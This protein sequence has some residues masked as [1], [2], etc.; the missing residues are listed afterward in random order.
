MAGDDLIAWA[1]KASGNGVPLDSVRQQ[2]PYTCGPAVLVAV[3]R[4]FGKGAD[5]RSIAEEADSNPNGTTFD[6]MERVLKH[7]G[8]TIERRD[9]LDA[10]SIKGLLAQGALVVVAL[11]AWRDP[12]PP[13]GGYAGEWNEGHY[14]APVAVDDEVVLFEDPAVAGRRSYLTSNEFAV[15][16]HSSDSDGTYLPGF[17]LVVHSTA[18]VVWGKLA[19]LKNP[20]RMG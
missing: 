16:W 10:Q 11:Q 14:V 19:K 20:V 4:Y 8:L 3:L 9:D 7:H 12:L 15:R 1:S 17:G 5:E 2:T 13:A 18:P 6:A